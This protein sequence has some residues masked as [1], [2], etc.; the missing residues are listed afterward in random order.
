MEPGDCL[1]LHS[2]GA[3]EVAVDHELFGL[4]RVAR[5][6][7]RSHSAAEAVAN[8]RHDIEDFLDGV[9]WPDDLCILALTRE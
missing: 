9:P 1:L 7:R 8:L 6:L 3:N 5:A 4:K 2:D